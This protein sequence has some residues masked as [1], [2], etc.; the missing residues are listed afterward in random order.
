MPQ[1]AILTGTLFRIFRKNIK[2]P[3]DTQIR[4]H[5]HFQRTLFAMLLHW[6][7]LISAMALGKWSLALKPTYMC[8]GQWSTRKTKIRTGTSVGITAESATKLTRVMTWG[9]VSAMAWVM[10]LRNCLPMYMRSDPVRS[11]TLP[12][13]CSSQSCPLNTCREH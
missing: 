6:R 11:L 1:Y 8:A 4:K 10:R 5:W 3:Q 7:H 13:W 9:I 2:Y 12:H